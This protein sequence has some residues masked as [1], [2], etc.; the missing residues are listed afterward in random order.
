M[1]GLYVSQFS[2]SDSGWSDAVRSVSTTSSIY[3]PYMFHVASGGSVLLVT[4]ADTTEVIEDLHGPICFT[5]LQ[6]TF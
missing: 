5:T 2:K 1:C 4:F 6:Q 3:F